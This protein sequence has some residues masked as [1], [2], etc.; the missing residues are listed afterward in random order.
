MKGHGAGGGGGGGGGGSGGGGSSGSSICQTSGA[1][2]G[3][4]WAVLAASVIPVRLKP[5][6]TSTVVAHPAIIRFINLDCA[7]CRPAC[8]GVMHTKQRM[9]GVAVVLASSVPAVRST[10]LARVRWCFVPLLLCRAALTVADFY[11]HL[12]TTPGSSINPTYQDY[13]DYLRRAH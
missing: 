13:L 3:A 11:R 4:A 9:H 10:G 12:L 5:T 7:P 8:T 2:P 6:A 1:R